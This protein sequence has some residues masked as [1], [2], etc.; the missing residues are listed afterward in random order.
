MEKIGFIGLGIMGKPMALNLLRAGFE[1][2]VYT[3]KIETIA[4]L[5][6]RGAKGATN[7]REVAENSTIVITMLPDSQTVKDVVFGVN[8]IIEGLKQGSLYIDMSTIEPQTVKCIYNRLVDKGVDMLDAPVSGGQKGAERGELSIMV[9]GSTCG[10]QRAL[11]VFRAIGKNIVYI[12]GIGSGQIAKAC[13]QIIVAITIQAIAESLTLAM[14]AG[15]DPALVRKALLGGF[16][17]SRVLCEH[18]ERMLTG[19]FT[20]GGRVE[21][22]LKDLRIALRIAEEHATPLLGASQV[23][24]LFEAMVSLGWGELDHSA[25][26]KVYQLLAGIDLT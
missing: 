18:G 20:P 7:P 15:V 1:L 3:R 12:G 17:D 21:L 10:F 16:A 4:E 26:I 8:G 19:N 22:H 6:S 14:K 11:P 2:I 25:V 9:G 13:N 23:T 5:V 24:S